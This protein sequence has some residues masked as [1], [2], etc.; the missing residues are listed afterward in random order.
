MHLHVDIGNSNVVIIGKPASGK[1]YS[2]KLL[3]H[4][5]PKHHV[6]HTDDYGKFGFKEGLY[7]L[8]MDLP[9]VKQPYIV[10]GILGYRLL[11]KGVELDVFYPDMVI[12]LIIPDIL[13]FRTYSAERPDKDV[14]YLKSF[15]A[16]CQ[17]IL[18][19]YKTMVNNK[20]P[21]WIHLNN[22]Y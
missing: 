8:L 20:P 6:I 12:E 4:D 7:R 1:T 3:K 19:D 11:R 5:N 21:Q 9:R 16:A 22:A 18:N 2:S 15:N 10:E 14:S 13:M 17:T